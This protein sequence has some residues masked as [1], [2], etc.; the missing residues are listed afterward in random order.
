MIISKILNQYFDETSYKIF[1]TYE[2][3]LYRYV[4]ATLMWKAEQKIIAFF[5]ELIPAQQMAKRN[6]LPHHNHISSF[7][8]KKL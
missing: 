6:F 7:I 8:R 2:D 3:A 1:K 4:V 5:K